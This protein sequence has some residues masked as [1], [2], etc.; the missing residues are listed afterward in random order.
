MTE[1]ESPPETSANAVRAFVVPPALHGARL[2][3]GI[4]QLVPE[5]SRARV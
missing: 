1:A 3:K 5:L 2:D 4:A